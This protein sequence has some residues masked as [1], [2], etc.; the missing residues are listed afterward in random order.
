MLVLQRNY[1]SN[2]QK[3]L[4]LQIHRF[5]VKTWRFFRFSFKVW[6]GLGTQTSWL[7]LG[8]H[9]LKYL[10]WLQQTRLESVALSECLK[11]RSEQHLKGTSYMRRDTSM[12]NRHLQGHF[13]VAHLP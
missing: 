1:N 13:I 4:Y 3:V 6:L 8:K 7:G 9:R 5:T 2:H 11:A 10:L 12:Q